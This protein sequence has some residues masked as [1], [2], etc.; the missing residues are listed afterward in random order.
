MSHLKTM[1]TQNMT[2]AMKT[3]MVMMMIGKL[4]IKEDIRGLK[5]SNEKLKVNM[6]MTINKKCSIKIKKI[7]R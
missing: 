4:N 7:K 3:T 2:M 6:V 1:A 5:V